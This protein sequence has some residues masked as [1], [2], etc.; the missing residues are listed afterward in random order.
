MALMSASD[1]RSIVEEYHKTELEDAMADL[2]EKIDRAVHDGELGTRVRYEF[3]RYSPM[4]QLIFDQLHKAGYCF[5][6]NSG[7]NA[8]P[9][10]ITIEW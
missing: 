2:A 9:F 5:E 7:H 8:E 4:A 6:V 10:S 1:A 3:S